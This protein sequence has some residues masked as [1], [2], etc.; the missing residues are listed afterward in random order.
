MGL[1]KAEK[2]AVETFVYTQTCYSNGTSKS[3]QHEF[4]VCRIYTHFFQASVL[5]QPQF[6]FIL[7]FRETCKD[8]GYQAPTA[9]PVSNSSSRKHQRLQL[10][11]TSLNSATIARKGNGSPEQAER[12]ESR[13]RDDRNVLTRWKY[14]VWQT[15][16]N[17][18]CWMCSFSP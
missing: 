17:K 9:T 6:I 7:E 16:F 15:V 13:E 11:K 18:Y 14:P 5:L 8:R 12:N 3:T 1:V 4:H 2:E 10:W